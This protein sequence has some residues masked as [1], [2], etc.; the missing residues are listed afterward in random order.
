MSLNNNNT[1]VIES[2]SLD[3]RIEA[4]LSYQDKNHVDNANVEAVLTKPEG[5]Y[6]VKDWFFGSNIVTLDGAIYYAKKSAGETPA[7]NENFGAGRFELRDAAD[8]PADTD[9]Y[10]NVLTPIT[11]SRQVFTSGYP[12][13][14]DT[15]DA[16]NTGDGVNV[17]SYATLWTTTS[18]SANTIQGGM[19]HDNASP[20]GATKLLTHF[21]ITS[22]AKTTSDT[23]KIFCNHALA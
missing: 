3:E 9:T 2:L 16:D 10:T 15:G 18:F 19:I 1:K 21:S 12:K 14:N 11:A 4:K 7:T 8:T 22:F 20:V 13:T 6:F 17:V 23:L 5:S